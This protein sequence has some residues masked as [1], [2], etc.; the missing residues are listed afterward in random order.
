MSEQH[1]REPSVADISDEGRRCNMAAD[2]LAREHE[3]GLRV[4]AAERTHARRAAELAALHVVQDIFGALEAAVLAEVRR[5]PTRS[6]LPALHTWGSSCGSWAA[7]RSRPGGAPRTRRCMSCGP[8]GRWRQGGARCSVER[9]GRMAV[10]LLL[11]AVWRRSGLGP[12]WVRSAH[13][14]AGCVSARGV[15]TMWLPKR[16]GWQRCPVVWAAGERDRLA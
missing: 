15:A 10:R 6:A 12:R 2:A 14:P 9:M 16:P 13:R 11:A 4:E 3:H 1:G 5:G 7:A 8:G